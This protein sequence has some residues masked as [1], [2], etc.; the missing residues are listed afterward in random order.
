M[1]PPH[2]WPPLLKDG[3][4][5]CVHGKHGRKLLQR[6]V[7]ASQRANTGTSCTIVFESGKRC[8]R[9]GGAWKNCDLGHEP[10]DFV[11]EIE[12]IWSDKKRK[13]KARPI[14]QPAR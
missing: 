10:A 12:R 7:K 4:A 5:D 13:G 14:F 3:I 2:R 6:S 1:P 11:A 9:D 8:I